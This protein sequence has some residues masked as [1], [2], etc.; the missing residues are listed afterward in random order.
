MTVTQFIYLFPIHGGLDC[1][2]FWLFWMTLLWAFCQLQCKL[3]VGRGFVSFHLILSNTFIMSGCLINIWGMSESLY[4]SPGV[5]V[6]E[7]FRAVVFRYVPGT[8]EDPDTLQRGVC[9][10]KKIF[11]RVLKHYLSSSLSFFTFKCFPD[12]WRHHSDSL[13]R[14]YLYIFV[15]KMSIL[16]SNMVNFEKYKP[17]EQQALWGPQ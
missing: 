16:T 7:F 10:G 4:M 14:M 1:F 9:E 2:Q 11:I 3:H 13:S 17:H 15:L 5:H 12:M 6:Q 8:L